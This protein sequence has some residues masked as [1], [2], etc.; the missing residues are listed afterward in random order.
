MY[1]VH[2]VNV[3]RTAVIKRRLVPQSVTVLATH[4]SNLKM[5]REREREEST[6]EINEPYTVHGCCHVVSGGMIDYQTAGSER[7]NN[8][9]TLVSVVLFTKMGI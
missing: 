3:F 5:R 8:T 9:S 1:Y 7:P 2:I 6:A 4:N